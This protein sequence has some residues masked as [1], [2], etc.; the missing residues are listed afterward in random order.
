MI[1]RMRKKTSKNET[2]KCGRMPTLTI[3]EDKDT[4]IDAFLF[5]TEGTNNYN[6]NVNTTN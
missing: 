2:D 1:F 3:I 4:S 5:K 6:Y